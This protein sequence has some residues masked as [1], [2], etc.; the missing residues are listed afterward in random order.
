M[1][2]CQMVYGGDHDATYCLVNSQ[3]PD[4]ALF[5]LSPPY[6]LTASQNVTKS[7]REVIR[8]FAPIFHQRE[9]EVDILDKLARLTV[10]WIRE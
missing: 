5:P 6:A 4:N 9:A 10:I 7:V 8:I 2:Q 3:I 1:V